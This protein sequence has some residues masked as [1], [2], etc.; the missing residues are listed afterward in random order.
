MTTHISRR[1]AIAFEQLESRDLMAGNVVASVQ[2][3]ML[4]LW[5]DGEAN[6][7]TL[8]Y[9]ASAK[10]YQVTGKDA[11][12]SPTTINGLNTAQTGNTVELG[13]VKT[14]AVYLNGGDDDFNIGS[15]QAADMVIG[16]WF[17]IN[18]GDGNDKVT[19]GT[20]GNEP[21]GAA[22]LTTSLRTG[23]SLG[24]DLGNGDDDLSMAQSDIGLSMK[25]DAGEGNDDILFATEFTPA[26][27]DELELFP[28]R[29]R[30]HA[31]V[32]LGG[33]VDTLDMQNVI[34]GGDLKIADF[35]GPADIDLHNM[36]VGKHIDID[37]GNEID[38]IAV[39]LVHAN[40]LS[41]DTNGAVDDVD[42]T[43]SRFKSINI[44]LGGSRDTMLIRNTTSSVATYLDGG[45]GDA[46]LTLTAN[47]LR[48]L[49]KRNFG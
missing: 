4:L 32:I 37:T 1:K 42:V 6:G 3:N 30:G 48:G 26:E 41:V 35:S 24:I 11:G 10:K 12:G 7:V 2:G 31:K 15:P 17:S 27:T 47:V 25:I 36:T 21:G 34:V 49:L 8:T 28:V 18:M 29:A 5:G 13:G 19:L 40:Q 16:K 44:K 33:G 43:K 39:D 45:T 38:A 14:V 46:R 22:P 20:A 23:T 9:N